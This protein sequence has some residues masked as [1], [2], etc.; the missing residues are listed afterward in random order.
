MHI[1]TQEVYDADTDTHAVLCYSEPQPIRCL[2]E[3]PKDYAP[4]DDLSYLLKPQAI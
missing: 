2:L 1:R 3:A 4:D